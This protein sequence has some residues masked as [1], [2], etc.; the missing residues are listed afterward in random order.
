[1]YDVNSFK[2]L[3]ERRYDWCELEIGNTNDASSVPNNQYA[4]L[5]YKMIV[6]IADLNFFKRMNVSAEMLE[7]V[8][9]AALSVPELCC[10]PS[11]IA[12]FTLLCAINNGSDV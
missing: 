2:R 10:S 12:S 4:Q 9:N 5:F 8:Y 11:L 7:D 1:M 6:P 3:L